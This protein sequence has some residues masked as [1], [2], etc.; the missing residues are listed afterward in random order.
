M[1]KSRPWQ[2]LHLQ[3]ESEEVPGPGLPGGGFF[4]VL[5]RSGVPVATRWLLP[6]EAASEIA[7]MRGSFPAPDAGAAASVAAG[8]ARGRQ[9]A[10]AASVVVCTRDR[11]ER[12]E[13]CLASLLRQSVPPGDIVVVD[14]APTSEATRSVV[15]RFP[16]ARYVREPRPGLDV[17]RNAGIRHAAGAI[18]AFVDDDVVIHPDWLVRLLGGFHHPA[19]AA[20]TG[21]VLP[22]ELATPAQRAFERHWSLGKGCRPREFG[23]GYLAATRARGCPAWEIGAGASMAFRARVFERVGPF[24]ER[25]DAGAAGCSGDSEMWYRILAAG[26]RCRYEPAAVVFHEHRRDDA[27]L[28][29]QIFAYMRG[30]TAALLVQF[31]RHRHAGNLRR[32]FATLPLHYGRRLLRRAP[33]G[34]DAGLPSTWRDEVSGWLSGIAFYLR[35]ARAG[36]PDGSAAAAVARP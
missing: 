26:W 18:V 8:E 14:N 11:P 35:H 22:L 6:E 9:L 10:P 24:D 13:R 15:A 2:I 31:Q 1:L 4:V 7:R 36:R 29:R 17:A 27:A 30:H 21:L 33:S 23:P 16:A 5:W 12:L 19:I 25:L 34:A 28:R 3:V 32:A 20:V